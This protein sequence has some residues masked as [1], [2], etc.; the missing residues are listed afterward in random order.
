MSV[1]EVKQK[2]AQDLYHVADNS[3]RGK[4]EVWHYFGIIENENNEHV[5]LFI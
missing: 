3:A 5:T 2:I 4:S 1:D